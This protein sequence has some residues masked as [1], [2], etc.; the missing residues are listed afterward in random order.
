MRL[1]FSQHKETHHERCLFLGSFEYT[2]QKVRDF[3]RIPLGQVT[4]L[5]KGMYKDVQPQSRATSSRIFDFRTTG[6]Y[7]LS[8]LDSSARNVEENF[9][10]IIRYMPEGTDSRS[11]S[12][13]IRN[14]PAIS[15]TSDTASPSS[16]AAPADQIAKAEEPCLLAFKA[17][18]TNLIRD[19]DSVSSET[20]QSSRVQVNLIAEYI[21]SACE[22][23]GAT[24]EEEAETFVT[25]EPIISLAE[26]TS[27]VGILDR[28]N[29][30]LKVGQP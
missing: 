5:Q 3:T 1:A 26:A 21:R 20:S 30:E 22:D 13:S 18:R 7:I 15:P 25:E 6:E 24:T 16:E 23:I 8:A 14:K 11:R 2:L 10:L 29:H 17:M 4:G 27:K 9:G 28:L 12:Y 19:L